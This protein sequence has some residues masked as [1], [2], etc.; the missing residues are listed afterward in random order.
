M[1]PLCLES[2]KD[3]GVLEPFVVA[4]CSLV[5]CPDSKSVMKVLQV[6]RTIFG[7]VRFA[8]PRGFS[9]FP[10][11]CHSVFDTQMAS[12]V[13]VH[14]IRGLQVNGSDEEVCG[15]LLG[16]SFSVYAWLRPAHPAL[17]EI[18]GQVPNSSSESIQEFDTKVLAFAQSNE[19]IVEKNKRDLMRKILKPVI[20]VSV[21]A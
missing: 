2:L 19:N 15:P 12:Y 18:L 3:A 13:L 10:L 11:Q 8:L 6:A 7:T 16:L 20:A 21:S 17:V 9:A 5:N 1:T 4:I 14:C